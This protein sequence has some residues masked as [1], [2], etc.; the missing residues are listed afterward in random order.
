MGEGR[1][2]ILGREICIFFL[3][4][5]FDIRILVLSTPPDEQWVHEDWFSTHQCVSHLCDVQ[6]TLTCTYTRYNLKS[7]EHRT[8]TISLVL[9]TSLILSSHIRQGYDK[10]IQKQSRSNT[11]ATRITSPYVTEDF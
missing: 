8:G 2:I 7:F 4:Q 3:K 1:S 6:K 11:I 9:S 5:F 10:L